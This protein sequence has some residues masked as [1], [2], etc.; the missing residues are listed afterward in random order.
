V[1]LPFFFLFGSFF[2]HVFPAL[3][4]NPFTESLFDRFKPVGN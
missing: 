4:R 3:M 1:D 2:R